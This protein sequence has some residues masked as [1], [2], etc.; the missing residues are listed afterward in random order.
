MRAI[1]SVALVASCSNVRFAM[2]LCKLRGTGNADACFVS[3]FTTSRR[4]TIGFVVA[5]G[6]VIVLVPHDIVT[7]TCRCWSP[8]V[9][10][11]TGWN[12]TYYLTRTLGVTTTR[13]A[14]TANTCAP[15]VRGIARGGHLVV[16]CGPI[17]KRLRKFAGTWVAVGISS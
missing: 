7:T 1:T 3:G 2:R 5:V 10:S 13:P 15:T 12:R 16:G 14:T 11:L 9:N 6:A 8:G 4:V 17:S